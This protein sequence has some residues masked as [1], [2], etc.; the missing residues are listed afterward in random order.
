MAHSL[1]PMAAQITSEGFEM[2]NLSTTV[3]YTDRE[4]VDI[5]SQS[6]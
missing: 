1:A 3:L 2:L 5:L 4:N 6:H